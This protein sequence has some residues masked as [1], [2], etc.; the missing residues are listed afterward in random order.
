MTG[1]QTGKGAHGRAQDGRSDLSLNR[2]IVSDL[3]EG[4]TAPTDTGRAGD[5]T[6]TG[7]VVDT[8]DDGE[9]PP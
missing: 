3:S 1:K 6:D 4:P 7:Q 8:P 9:S 2:E 5:P